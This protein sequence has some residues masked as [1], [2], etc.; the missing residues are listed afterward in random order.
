MERFLPRRWAS[1]AQ[2]EE[3]LPAAAQATAAHRR[4]AGGD[5]F[6]AQ[7][8]VLLGERRR[9]SGGKV[10][11]MPQRVL[12]ALR[13]MAARHRWEEAAELATEAGRNMGKQVKSPG[14]ILSGAAAAQATA[15]A[16]RSHWQAI[17]GPVPPPCSGPQHRVKGAR[18]PT[19][20]QR[21]AEAQPLA[22]RSVLYCHARLDAAATPKRRGEGGA[23]QQR[24]GPDSYG[25]PASRPRSADAPG[26]RPPDAPAA[27]NSRGGD[28]QVST[29]EIVDII[30][31]LKKG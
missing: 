19:G 5:P 24:G 6:W 10:K 27:D 17:C 1:L 22:A 30:R 4:E 18:A 3:T 15:E 14:I 13:R 11:A 16:F 2:V 9:A 12:M 29:L 8:L 20:A 7:E 28:L 23:R 25:P 26:L 31:S 21:S